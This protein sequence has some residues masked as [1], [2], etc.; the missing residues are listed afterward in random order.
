MVSTNKFPRK[1]NLEH[2]S[3]NGNIVSWWGFDVGNVSGAT[4]LDLVGSNDGTLINSPTISTD[5][6]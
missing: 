1:V 6:P 2:N 4:V 5:V 3:G